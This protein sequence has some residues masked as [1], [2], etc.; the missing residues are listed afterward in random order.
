MP[1]RGRSRGLG[2][3]WELEEDWGLAR[4]SSW[5][6]RGKVSARVTRGAGK[7]AREIRAGGANVSIPVVCG[8]MVGGDGGDTVG[9]RCRRE[10]EVGGGGGGE[11]GRGAE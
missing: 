7:D 3:C 11:R 1:G 2:V 6:G 8:G 10:E 9:F 5:R 4:M